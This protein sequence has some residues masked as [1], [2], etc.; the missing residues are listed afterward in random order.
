MFNL[1][2]TT[3]GGVVLAT[4]L[5]AAVSVESAQQP[6]TREAASGDASGDASRDAEGDAKGAS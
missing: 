5:V 6:T 3:W 2:V 1:K 4:M